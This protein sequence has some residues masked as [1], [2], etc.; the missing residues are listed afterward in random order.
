[1]G[2]DVDPVIVNTINNG[3]VH[4]SEPGLEH[5]VKDVIAA[6]TLRASTKPEVA[7]AHL[8]AVPPLL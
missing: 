7:D 6:G 3:E 1:M 5:L 4:I 2:V 8:I